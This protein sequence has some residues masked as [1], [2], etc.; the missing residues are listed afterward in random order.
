MEKLFF[1]FLELTSTKQRKK[2]GNFALAFRPVGKK[3]HYN[4][5]NEKCYIDLN[6]KCRISKGTLSN[7]EN[8]AVKFKRRNVL[9]TR[10]GKFILS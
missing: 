4:D 7:F 2:A 6:K 1:F 10:A 3:I 9:F 5:L 8:A